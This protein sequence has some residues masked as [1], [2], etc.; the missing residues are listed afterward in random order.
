VNRPPHRCVI[1]GLKGSG[2]LFAIAWQTDTAGL[3]GRD[4]LAAP[5]FRSERERNHD[6][7]LAFAAVETIGVTSCDLRTDR[8]PAGMVPA[9]LT[10]GRRL[11]CW[12]REL[13]PPIS[14]E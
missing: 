7:I 6:R 8:H 5:L 4:P 12:H 3:A 14:P 9:G 10:P 2:C 1:Q 13:G 11:G